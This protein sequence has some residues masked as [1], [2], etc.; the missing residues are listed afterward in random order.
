MEKPTSSAG[1][2]VRIIRWIVRILSGLFI[3]LCLLFFVGEALIPTILFPAPDSTPLT[4]NAMLQLALFGLSL[5]GLA[6]AWKWEAIGGLMALAAY[7]AVGIVNPK[8]FMAVFFL[9]LLA[10][11]FLACWWMSRRC[12]GRGE[13][14]SHG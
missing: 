2:R 4:G 8:A 13:A 3:I 1:R 11:L 7:V 14:E 5:L 9:P 12:N 6:L 10:L